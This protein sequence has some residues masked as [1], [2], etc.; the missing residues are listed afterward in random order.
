MSEKRTF[1]RSYLHRGGLSRNSVPERRLQFPRQNQNRSTTKIKPID[2]SPLQR[3]NPYKLH[4]I[5]KK[6]NVHSL[7][8]MG[9]R[10]GTDSR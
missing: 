8:E 3:E 1:A 6:R 4:G 7:H 5:R 9:C 10:A 2:F